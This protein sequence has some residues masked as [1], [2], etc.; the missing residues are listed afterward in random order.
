MHVGVCGNVV[1]PCYGVRFW[2][3]APKGYRMVTAVS[4]DVSGFF[5]F[6]A[7]FDEAVSIIIF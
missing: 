2:H 7:F 6:G 5:L 4:I 1:F 3:C